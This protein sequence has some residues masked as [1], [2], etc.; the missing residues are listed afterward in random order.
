MPKNFRSGSLAAV[1]V[2]LAT[3]S[4]S[5]A[6][7]E[8]LSMTKAVSH[9]Q[10]CCC[11]LSHPVGVPQSTIAPSTR[12]AFGPEIVP[13]QIRRWSGC[14]TDFVFRPAEL[15]LQ[16]RAHS[17]DLHVEFLLQR[18]LLRD[19]HRQGDHVQHQEMHHKQRP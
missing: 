7:Q 9:A 1:T 4:Y 2:R 10:Q 6:K 3:S 16:S 13:A 17:S 18:P 8:R 12:R 15:S 11:I 14:F 5:P 19:H